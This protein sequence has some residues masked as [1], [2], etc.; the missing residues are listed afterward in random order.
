MR[1]PR[2]GQGPGFGSK[3]NTNRWRAPPAIQE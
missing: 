2:K 3:T 1:A